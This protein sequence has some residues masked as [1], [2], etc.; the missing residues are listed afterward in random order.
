MHSAC[1]CSLQTALHGLLHTLQRML[2]QQLQDAD[3]LAARARPACF[4]SLPQ[5]GERLGQV[6]VAQHGA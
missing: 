2:G 5:P 1:S 4:Q 6:P 3:V